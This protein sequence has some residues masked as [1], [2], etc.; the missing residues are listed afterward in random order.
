[1]QEMAA[2]P[3]VVFQEWNSVTRDIYHSKKNKKK[4]VAA[5][6][7]FFSDGIWRG[8]VLSDFGHVSQSCRARGCHLFIRQ[9]RWNALAFLFQGWRLTVYAW[10]SSFGIDGPFY[11]EALFGREGRSATPPLLPP[12]IHT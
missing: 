4:L 5:A 11:Y 8:L 10:N 2:D 9:E 12:H 3:E 7:N 1:M 6:N